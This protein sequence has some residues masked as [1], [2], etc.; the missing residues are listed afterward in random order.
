MADD[1]RDDALI[2]RCL[3]HDEDAW[4]VLVG[5]YTSYVYS[6][7]LRGFGF[8]DEEARDVVQ[9]SFLRVFESLR[10]YRGEGEF[11]GWLRQVARTTSLA[12][13]RRRRPVEPID[14]GLRDPAQEETLERIERAFELREALALLDRPCREVL[15]LFFF[16]GRPYKEIAAALGVPEGTVASR[17]ARCLGKLRPRVADD[18]GDCRPV[19]ARPRVEET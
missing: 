1:T 12:H 2:A 3:A 4:R 16:E 18:A 15:S 5:R 19:L 8:S 6:I 10:G 9:E 11:R 13:L 14:E 17:L 7:A